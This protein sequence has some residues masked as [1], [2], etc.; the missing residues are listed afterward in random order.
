MSLTNRF[1]VTINL[2]IQG[3]TAGV[4]IQPYQP[5]KDP[6]VLW[7]EVWFACKLIL[8]RETIQ[9]ESRAFGSYN[10]VLSLLWIPYEMKR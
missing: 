1:L 7:H 6:S 3:D 4:A 5:V 10:S 2:P 9:E 8:L